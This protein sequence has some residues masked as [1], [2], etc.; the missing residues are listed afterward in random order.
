[1]IGNLLGKRLEDYYTQQEDHEHFQK[2]K[3]CNDHVDRQWKIFNSSQVIASYEINSTQSLQ[4]FK[5]SSTGMLRAEVVN[6]QNNEIDILPENE[7]YFKLK[8]VETP[9]QATSETSLFYGLDPVT[10]QTIC[11]LLRQHAVSIEKTYG[12]DGKISSICIIQQK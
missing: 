2:Q 11:D 8:A 5:D 3:E 12:A 9:N 10:Q 6:A 1:M 4:F 7:I